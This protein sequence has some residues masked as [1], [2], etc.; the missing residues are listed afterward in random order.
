[1]GNSDVVTDRDLKRLLAEKKNHYVYK[2]KKTVFSDSLS[3]M[4]VLK[5]L[6]DTITVNL[7][8]WISY[9]AAAPASPDPV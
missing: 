3:Q 9:A 4:Q 5:Y 6:L 7:G 2:G 8:A 1:M